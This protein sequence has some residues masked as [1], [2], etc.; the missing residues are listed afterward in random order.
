MLYIPGIGYVPLSGLGGIPGLNLGGQRRA[1]A[2]DPEGER[3]WKGL[4]TMPAVT[5]DTIKDLTQA[6][7][8]D[9]KD[10][11]TIMLLGKGGVGKS[12]TLNS[13]LNEQAATVLPF[14]AGNA[15]TTVYTR[16]A[17]SG[18]LLNIIDTPSILDQD[19]VSE[20]V[21]VYVVMHRSV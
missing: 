18:F 10:D 9:E 11:L 21:S 13:L 6:L 17:P 16:R 1:E 2:P 4:A 15:R 3:E 12:S 8:E 19:A 7:H 5:Q 14:N 20:G